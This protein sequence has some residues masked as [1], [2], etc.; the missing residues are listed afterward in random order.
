MTDHILCQS[1]IATSYNMIDHTHQPFYVTYVV[2][3]YDILNIIFIYLLYDR[4]STS[5]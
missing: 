3:K 4:Y 5:I 2:W 1:I